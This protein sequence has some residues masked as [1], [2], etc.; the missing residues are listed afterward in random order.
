ML[1]KRSL[2]G[3]AVRKCIC[4]MIRVGGL[5]RKNINDQNA[6]RCFTVLN[7][8][9]ELLFAISVRIYYSVCGFPL[10]GSDSKERRFVKSDPITYP[11]VL[12]SHIT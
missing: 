11:C 7:I 5:L 1:R 6:K 2:A 12:M 3:Y 9:K 4:L 8:N 10:I